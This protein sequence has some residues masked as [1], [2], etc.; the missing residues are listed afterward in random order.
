MSLSNK[1]KEYLLENG[2][3]SVGY[4]DITGFSP[5]KEL[6]NGEKKSLEICKTHQ[7][8]SMSMN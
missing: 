2:A 6:D 1:L 3:T 8:K 7:P 5:K 4:A